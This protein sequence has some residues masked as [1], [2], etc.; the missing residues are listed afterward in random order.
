MRKRKQKETK[1]TLKRK[2]SLNFNRKRK[3]FD[4]R[5]SERIALLIMEIAA[6]LFL[7]FMTVEAFG[8]RLRVLGNSMEPTLYEG[9]TLLMNRIA[10]KLGSPHHNDVIVFRPS[11]NLNAQ[12]SI[13]RVV[14]V[15]GDTVLIY[16]G[17]L[18]VNG[19]RYR[20]FADTDAIIE[21]GRAGTEI[22]LSDDEYFV[23][24]DNR[25]S[26]EDS[27]YETIGNVSAK[28]IYGQLY[29]NVT[30]ERFGFIE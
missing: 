2:D 15:P 24:G 1:H 12:Y 17:V 30:G 11:G 5:K 21:P 16:N 13:K 8:M 3:K 25:N 14:G 19:E 28:E 9:D 7:S 26:S 29:F 22:R 23:L 18:Y 6:V 27:R 20:D 10:Y 4:F